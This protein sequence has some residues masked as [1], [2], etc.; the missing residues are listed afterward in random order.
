MAE[1]CSSGVTL[2]GGRSLIKVNGKDFEV[3]Q[4]IRARGTNVAKKKELMKIFGPLWSDGHCAKFLLYD[5]VFYSVYL[6]I[7]LKYTHQRIEPYTQVRIFKYNRSR[8]I[9]G[10]LANR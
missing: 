7:H 1:N 8:D 4:S 5:S 6:N 2:A 10:C 3:G 9:C